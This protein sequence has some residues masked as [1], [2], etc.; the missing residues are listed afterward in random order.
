[1]SSPLPAER[2]NVGPRRVRVGFGMIEAQAV[3]GAGP[4]AAALVFADLPDG[5]AG[6]ALLGAVLDPGALEEAMQ[7]AVGGHPQAAV[8]G[9]D[10][11]R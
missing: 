8:A 6:Q 1:M 10:A 9:A 2:L 3:G 4:D 11:R 7:A 5:P